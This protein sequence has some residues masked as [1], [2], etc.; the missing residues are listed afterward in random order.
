M[1]I[2]RRMLINAGL[3]GGITIAGTLAYTLV[4]GWDWLD[5][6]FMTLTTITTVGFETVHP[7]DPL[8]KAITLA[9]VVAG[10]GV[11]LYTL[12]ILAGIIVEGQIQQLFRRN[13][14]QKA[15]SSLADHV[16]VC[17][18]GRMGKIVAEQLK[19]RKIPFVIVEKDPH[20]S[21]S[22]MEAG[23]L[24]VEGDATSDEVLR[25]SSIGTARAIICVTDTD[26]QNVYITL[27]ARV[28]NPAIFILARCNEEAAEEKLRRAGADKVI[29][30]YRL[31][32]RQLA[33]FIARPHLMELLD[34]AVESGN[35][36][37]EMQEIRVPPG[38]FLDGVTLLK[39]GLRPNYNIIVV[40]ARPNNNS[41]MIFNPGMDFNLTAGDILIVLGEP[42][43]MRQFQADLHGI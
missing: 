35:W 20:T 18:Y 2:Q 42:E 24:V 16:I 39:S 43:K 34:I 23:Y 4:L 25:R 1:T 17:G 6:L 27:S 9:L 15:A 29:F 14:M 31:G 12:S 28:L 8:G 5:S 40:G 11:A 37:L 26:A 38:S 3:L 32:A 33:D 41:R 10:C 22:I 19:L 30:P 13:K 7:L 21:S 36:Q